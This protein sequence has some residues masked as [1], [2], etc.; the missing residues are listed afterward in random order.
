MIVIHHFQEVTDPMTYY[1]KSP[2]RDETQETVREHT[3]K[4]KVLAQTYGKSF[5]EEISAGLCGVFHDF[6]KYSSAFQQ[7]LQGTRTGVDHAIAGAVFLYGLRKKALHP[8]IE[9][10]AAHHSH[11]I[12]CDDLS[13]VMETALET[14]GPI[15]TLCGKQAALCGGKDY[16]EARMA[17]QSD[18]PDFRFPKLQTISP[19]PLF[20]GQVD[21]MLHTRMLFS[22]LV[23]ADYTAS[24][25]I[26]PEEDVPL[27][28]FTALKN[29]YNYCENLRKNSGADP[30]LNQ[31]R[32]RL[33]ELCGKAGERKGG[34]FTLTAPT[35]TGKTLALLHFAL[36]HCQYTGKRRIFVVLPFL[37]LIEQSAKVYRKILPH[38]MEDHSQA[39]L[40]EEMRDYAARWSEPFIITTSVRFFE[41]LFSDRPTDCRKLHNLANSVILFDEAQSLPI[42]VLSPTL[43]VVKELCDRYGC[44]VVFSTATQPDYTGLQEVNW[45][46]SELLPE[47]DAFYKALRRTSTHWEIETPTPLEDIAERMA[48]QKN[49]CAIVNLRSHARSLYRALSRRCPDEELFLLSTDLCPAHRTKIIETIRRRQKERLPCRVVSTQC[50]EAGVDLDFDCL[51]R[52]LAPLEAII[53]AAGRCNRNGKS[54][55]GELWVFVPSEE[56]L[57]PDSHYENAATIV[58]AMQMQRPIDIHDPESIRRYYRQLL[59]TF[60]GDKKSR[61]LE[62]ALSERDF[63]VVS[64]TYRFIEQQGVQVVVPYEEQTELYEQIRSEALNIGLTKSLLRMAAPLT[65]T[66]YDRELAERICEP[67]FFAGKSKIETRESPYYIILTGQEDCYDR[68][69]GFCPP[70]KQMLQNS[71][72]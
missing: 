67:L 19:Q 2:Q 37:S 45:Q 43:K 33:F 44:S 40:P 18:F 12:S 26:S 4:V 15:M 54:T 5:G 36:R 24:S 34:L 13:G 59:S 50:I 27:D 66:C 68:K 9:V 42:S 7:V 10:V 69:M 38:V 30:I 72:W 52:A 22:C 28:V 60:R 41:S 53:Q 65:V 61:T 55:C 3:Q 23:D 49:V 17:F 29:L 6:G 51:Y 11:L 63:S 25:H 70:D 48:E 20:N 21:S 71:F 16:Q 39:C 47:Y 32:N 31:F 62:K 64:Q 56:H 14:E 57:Y 35:G 58:R 46:A 1:A 8:I